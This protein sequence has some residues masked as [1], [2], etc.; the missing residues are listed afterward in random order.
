MKLFSTISMM[1]LAIIAS[2][3]VSA[4]IIKDR[5]PSGAEH[6]FSTAVRSISHDHIP[7]GED[8]ATAK[9]GVLQDTDN[10]PAVTTYI[11]TA[12]F[13]TTSSPTATNEISTANAIPTTDEISILNSTVVRANLNPPR[14][15]VLWQFKGDSCNGEGKVAI[16][17]GRNYGDP[18]FEDCF[19][20]DDDTNFY[21]LEAADGCVTTMQTGEM[22]AISV[23]FDYWLPTNV[24]TTLEITGRKDVHLWYRCDGR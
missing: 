5:N 6:E 14:R 13:S 12:T 10:A 24:C 21:N 1:A 3:T 8:I 19:P 11:T 9:A 18:L 7:T 17:D 4:G 15:I 16:I 22:C 2:T 20:I 23:G